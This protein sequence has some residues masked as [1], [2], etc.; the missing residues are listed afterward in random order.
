MKTTR[1]YLFQDIKRKI[2]GKI[3]GVTN[4]C[5]H[6]III[7]SSSLIIFGLHWIFSHWKDDAILG[8]VQKSLVVLEKY[9]IPIDILVTILF[10]VLLHALIR[11]YKHYKR[12]S[13]ASAAGLFYCSINSDDRAIKKSDAYLYEVS[14]STLS[15]AI[16]GA[17]GWWTFGAEHSPLHKSFESCRDINVLLFDPSTPELEKRAKDVGVTAHEYR[18]EIYD[19][20]NFLTALRSDYRKRIELKMYTTYPFWKYIFIDSCVWVWQYPDRDHVNK[21]PCY[22]FKK[23]DGKIGMYDHMHAQFLKR[24]SNNRFWTYNFDKKVLEKN[25]EYGNL[26]SKNI[27]PFA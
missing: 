27:A 26:I 19:S 2:F 3:N 21:S 4:V 17:T 16:S 7:I 20:I 12:G 1:P 10:V 9:S 8:Y 23:T 5:Q 18:K 25:D 15:I 13:A 14:C 11:L 24:W 22:A 6:A